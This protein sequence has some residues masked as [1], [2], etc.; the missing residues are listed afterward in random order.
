MGIKS[1]LLAYVVISI[2][3]ALSLLGILLLSEDVS[4][5]QPHPKPLVFVVEEQPNTF[6][7]EK[8]NPLAW[9][10][11]S[12]TQ[13]HELN[14]FRALRDDE[15]DLDEFELKSKLKNVR[16]S[17]GGEFIVGYD[18]DIDNPDFKDVNVGYDGHNK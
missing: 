17:I 1:A 5:E 2:L 12:K 7:I 10:Q 18:K 16:R 11:E 13:R 14:L 15:D 4:E 9:I 6:I 3:A 8:N